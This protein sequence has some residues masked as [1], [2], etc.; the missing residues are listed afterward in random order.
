MGGISM[1]NVHRLFAASIWAA[2]STVVL[3]TFSSGCSGTGSAD[4]DNEGLGEIS[5]AIDPCQQCE[6]RYTN[7]V[8]LANSNL[9]ECLNSCSNPTICY[10]G[11]S[12]SMLAC[13]R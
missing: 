11:Y 6:T 2:L 5:Q 12:S 4:G 8:R 9:S 10:Q 7:C 13:T 1:K 3:G